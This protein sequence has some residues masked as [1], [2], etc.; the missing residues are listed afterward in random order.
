MVFN[1]KNKNIKI[2]LLVLLV[3]ASV[4]CYSMMRRDVEGHANMSSH[5][6]TNFKI[7]NK[8][9]KNGTDNY[10]L[11]PYAADATE[12]KFSTDTPLSSLS[13]TV[14]SKK[15]V[16]KNGGIYKYIIKNGYD[17]YRFIAASPETDE[18]YEVYK[19]DIPFTINLLAADAVV[20]SVVVDSVVDETVVD[21]L[22]DETVTGSPVATPEQLAE[23]ERLKA[24]E[25]SQN[26]IV[27]TTTL[28]TTISIAE[29]TIQPVKVEKLKT[30]IAGNAS[31]AGSTNGPL[32]H[33]NV[34]TTLTPAT[35]N[36]PT[37]LKIDIVVPKDESA[38]M[39]T[40][41]NDSMFSSIIKF[42][43]AIN[44]QAMTGITA[45][46]IPVPIAVVTE[47]FGNMM[48]YFFGKKV[49]E[50][51]TGLAYRG[52]V[53]LRL[54]EGDYSNV[55]TKSGETLDIT[56]KKSNIVLIQNG[57]LL[58]KPQNYVAPPVTPPKDNG[59]QTTYIKDENGVYVA[60][61][62][63]AT[64]S[65][66]IPGSDPALVT[67]NKCPFYPD[68]SVFETAMNNPSNPIVNPVNSLNPV[69]YSQTLFGPHAIGMSAN[70]PCSSCN[71]NQLPA[72][73]NT[74][75]CSS[76]NV[77]RTTDV[78]VDDVVVDDA[79]VNDLV[80]NPSVVPAVP[81]TPDATNAPNVPNV[82]NQINSASNRM[83]AQNGNDGNGMANAGPATS[84][85][86]DFNGAGN[87]NP[88]MAR[89]DNIFP[90]YVP[91][92][93]DNNAEPRPVLANFSTFGS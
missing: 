11:K 1:F 45:E 25:T 2:I 92:L 62:S 19:I 91:N 49:K 42:N 17:M 50:G 5:F 21:S 29:T 60:V 75:S 37:F 27:E 68:T 28:S 36:E 83:M 84:S 56:M 77:A 4:A 32:L 76:N 33:S 90:E 24:L 78:V 15:D 16:N 74:N 86:S 22:V 69:D 35:A 71:N 10:F 79:T 88:S 81:T 87:M 52:N 51:M 73:T 9:Y 12:I 3:L 80:E 57:G 85:Y 44:S 65:C 48:S 26:A 93:N 14:I 30:L 6:E 53:L 82:F 38:A 43:A 70:T 41:L 59:G 89:T 8:D 67:N 13:G 20:D 47:G 72:A 66:L 39:I 34:I 61:N 55:L 18:S 7:Y 63:Q 40:K 54:R 58:V 23:V 64:N 46:A 31:I